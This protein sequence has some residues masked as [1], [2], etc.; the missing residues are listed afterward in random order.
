MCGL[1]NVFAKLLMVSFH[2]VHISIIITTVMRS[3]LK[4]VRL[5]LL[6]ANGVP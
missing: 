5:S 3:A 2:F 4:G 6:R 1:G